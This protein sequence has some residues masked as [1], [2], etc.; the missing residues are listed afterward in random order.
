MVRRSFVAAGLLSALL[1][2]GA[3]A[4]DKE[5]KPEVYNFGTLRA[6]TVGRPRKLM[7]EIARL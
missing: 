3:T 2:A 5:I 6:M 1:T 4:G 7:C